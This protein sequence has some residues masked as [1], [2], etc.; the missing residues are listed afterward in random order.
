MTFT[1]PSHFNFLRYFTC[2]LRALQ[3]NKDLKE[4]LAQIETRFIEMV[5]QTL[6]S[7]FSKEKCYGKRCCGNRNFANFL[8]DKPITDMD[9][10]ASPI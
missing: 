5:S 10:G 2:F 4:Q 1:R 3:Q 6:K 7:I 9:I 8:A